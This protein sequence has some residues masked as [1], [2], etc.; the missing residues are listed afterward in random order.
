MA[1]SASTRADYKLIRVS[2][3]PAD[4]DPKTPSRFTTSPVAEA[5]AALLFLYARV[6]KR[7]LG[8]VEGV[9]RAKM[10]ER[11]P[12]VLGRAEAQAVLSRLHGIPSLV[13]HLL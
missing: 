2:P 11:L 8:W 5:L 10:P 3:S 9:I 1:A 4:S 7:K 12:V 13:C 6:L